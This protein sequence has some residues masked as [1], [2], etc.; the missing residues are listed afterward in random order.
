MRLA[1]DIADSLL[2]LRSEVSDII[3]NARLITWTPLM[4]RANCAAPSA[5]TGGGKP[6]PSAPNALFPFLCSTSGYPPIFTAKAEVPDWRPL[7]EEM[8]AQAPRSLGP[9]GIRSYTAA[10]MTSF[11]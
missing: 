9:G 8:L 7:E 6:K 3:I 2:E 10:M 5:A 11:D 1:A 4:R